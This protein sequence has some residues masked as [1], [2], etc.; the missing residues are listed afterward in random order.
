[1][2]LGQDV[3]VFYQ[4]GEYEV[5]HNVTEISMDDEKFMMY[6][7]LHLKNYSIPR[8]QLKD[9]PIMTD[10]F[11]RFE[12]EQAQVRHRHPYVMTQTWGG[13]IKRFTE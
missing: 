7:R 13:Y 4:N 10:F 6:S 1:M 8:K 5:Y 2:E 9:H 11:E 3:K 12:A